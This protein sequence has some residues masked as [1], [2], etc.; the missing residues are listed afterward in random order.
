M[1][2]KKNAFTLVELMVVVII[3]GILTAVS[4]PL[5][6]NMKYKA[7]TSEAKA[8]LGMFAKD[9]KMLCMEFDKDHIGSIGELKTLSPE[10]YEHYCLAGTTGAKYTYF[11]QFY[12]VSMTD[13][14]NYTLKATTNYDVDPSHRQVRMIVEDGN[15]TWDDDLTSKEKKW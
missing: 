11:K 4:V 3:I 2:K 6:K 13:V 15:V 5:Y 14:K 1:F 8:G 7:I 9:L 12:I 10:T